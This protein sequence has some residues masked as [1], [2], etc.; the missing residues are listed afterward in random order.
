MKHR[1]LRALQA[2]VTGIAAALIAGTSAVTSASA[3]PTY[4]TYQS[5]FNGGCLTASA[6]TTTVFT[7]TCQ[8]WQA[9]DW[10]WVDTANAYGQHQLMSRTRGLCLTTEA[11]ASRNGLWLSNC[12]GHVGQYWD[13]DNP[14]LL[15]SDAS[16]DN[17]NSLRVSPGATSV[18]SSNVLDDE[19][20]YDIDI[21]T[22]LWL[23]TAHS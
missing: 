18:F 11:T 3:A 20:L 15:M 5:Q 17:G 4:W 2:V 10:D 16:F 21:K 12:V 6:S 13:N 22:H 7:D 9:Q 23:A 8:H 1:R 14:S 19:A